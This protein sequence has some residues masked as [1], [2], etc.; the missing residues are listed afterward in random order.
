MGN[1]TLALPDDLQRRMRRH[2]DI[3]WSEVVR[4]SILQKIEV[5]EAMDRISKKSKL[6]KRDIDSLSAR[7]KRE[8]SEELNRL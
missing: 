4:K 3:R 1:L 5:L 7:I 6:T 8:T 2:S